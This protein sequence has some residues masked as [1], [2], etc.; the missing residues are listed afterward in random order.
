MKRNKVN[1]ILTCCGSEVSPGKI[2]SLKSVTERE[3]H[4]IGVDMNADGLGSHF[5]DK[6]Y[7][8]PRGDSADYAD[9]M[10]GIC[11]RERVHVILPAGDADCLALAKHREEFDRIGNS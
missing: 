6:F 3:V 8:V 4:V 7:Q 9:V 5:A 11:K 2:A 1:V 10:L